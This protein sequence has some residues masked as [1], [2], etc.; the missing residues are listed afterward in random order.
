MGALYALLEYVTKIIHSTRSV[1]NITILLKKTSSLLQRRTHG[2]VLL[3]DL[4]TFEKDRHMSHGHMDTWSHDHMITWSHGHMV[5]W[6]SGP[7]LCQHPDLPCQVRGPTRSLY[8]YIPQLI[9]YIYSHCIPTQGSTN[10]QPRYWWQEVTR[11]TVGLGWAWFPGGS[12]V[13]P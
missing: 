10:P 12:R 8:K 4:K 2:N 9:I 13:D 11:D 3:Q 5:T 1:Q 6:S 7:L